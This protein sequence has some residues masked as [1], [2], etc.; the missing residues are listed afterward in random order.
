MCGSIIKA[1]SESLHNRV[2]PIQWY[3]MTP[4][5]AAFLS[6][7]FISISMVN[8]YGTV[9]VGLLE[10]YYYYKTFFNNLPP[11]PRHTPWEEGAQAPHAWVSACVSPFT[12]P[13]RCFLKSRTRENMRRECGIGHRR[14]R[15]EDLTIS[16]DISRARDT[17]FYKGRKGY[18][19][20]PMPPCTTNF[21]AIRK[22]SE[23][24]R[25]PRNMIY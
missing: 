22:F 17:H 16:V 19:G 2:S 25:L 7:S 8:P 10:Q 21:Q 18:A 20:N 6:T 4:A 3:I 11:P 1:T 24:T 14:S 5:C 12:R 13:I 23:P 9:S 15:T